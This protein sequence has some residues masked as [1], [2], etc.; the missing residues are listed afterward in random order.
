MDQTLFEQFFSYVSQGRSRFN[1]TAEDSEFLFIYFSQAKSHPLAGV[2]NL[3]KIV[4]EDY[5][6]KWLCPTNDREGADGPDI[7][8]AVLFLRESRKKPV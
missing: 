6:S 1:V 8:R 5:S 2:Q 7:V 3:A 4:Y